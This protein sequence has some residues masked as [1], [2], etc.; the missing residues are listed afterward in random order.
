[1]M[2]VKEKLYFL[3]FILKNVDFNELL[4]KDCQNIA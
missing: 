3:K 4:I 2:T 1:M